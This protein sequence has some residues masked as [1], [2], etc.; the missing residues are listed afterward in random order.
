MKFISE[1]II[2]PEAEAGEPN[3]LLDADYI[4]ALKTGA[5]SCL[6]TTATLAHPSNK[7]LKFRHCY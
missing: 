3:A 4:T 6:A 5:A 2:L 7:H 1:V